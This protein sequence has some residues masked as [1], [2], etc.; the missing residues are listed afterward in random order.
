MI[1][2]LFPGDKVGES[3]TTQFYVME[4]K[5]TDEAAILMCSPT[6]MPPLVETNPY[7]DG[8]IAAEDPICE[9]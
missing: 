5:P 8:W 4:H 9:L 6:R 3:Y 2:Q 1:S 7:C